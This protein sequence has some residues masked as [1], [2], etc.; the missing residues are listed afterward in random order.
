MSISGVIF[1]KIPLAYNAAFF[2]SLCVCLKDAVV[3]LNAKLSAGNLNESKLA[4]LVLCHDQ[5]YEVVELVNKL[6]GLQFLVFLVGSNAFLHN[7][8]MFYFDIIFNQI[9]GIKGKVVDIDIFYLAWII[10]DTSRIVF[11][12]WTACSFVHEVIQL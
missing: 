8:I 7:D 6:F 11:F 3:N 10:F 2:C 5:L 9:Y 4:E 12:F 1:R